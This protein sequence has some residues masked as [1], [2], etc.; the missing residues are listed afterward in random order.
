MTHI[1]KTPLLIASGLLLA[2]L[3]VLAQAAS[4][5]GAATTAG[6][7][8]PTPAASSEGPEQPATN[9]PAPSATTPSAG[10]TQFTGGIAVDGTPLVANG[11]GVR[12]RFFAKVY[13]AALYLPAR[14]SNTA[15]ILGSEAPA[16]LHIVMLRDLGADRFVE[17]LETGLAKNLPAARYA[18]L[19]APRAELAAALR[20]VGEARKGDRIE[21]L[22]PP[23]G[24]TRLLVNG[25]VRAEIDAPGF[26][27]AL[28]HIWLGESPVDP[29]LKEGLLGRAPR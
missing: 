27:A 24:K 16:A 1:P 4:Y 9:A 14:S 5:G 3:A 28:L 19:A 12:T 18:Q 23:S 21:L 15:A 11:A 25:S 20:A 22:R 7:E 29:A 2:T 13:A 6:Y 17:A 8:L 26:F 10:G